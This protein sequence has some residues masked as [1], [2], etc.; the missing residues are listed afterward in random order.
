MACKEL[1]DPPI[2][3]ALRI[4]K[5]EPKLALPKTLQRSASRT[6]SV[7]EQE[8]PTRTKAR[9]DIELARAKASNN[10]TRLPKRAIFLVDI[11]LPNT[12]RPKTD[13]VLPIRVLARSEQVDARIW[14]PTILIRSA[15]PDWKIPAT[16][17][18]E[19]ALLNERKE[20]EDPKTAK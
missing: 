12:I 19:P 16:E 4:E 3:Q 20:G 17:R 13:A 7:T 10:D 9:K 14:R 18:P 2:R 15:E 6:A 1:T 5:D 11:V 8:L